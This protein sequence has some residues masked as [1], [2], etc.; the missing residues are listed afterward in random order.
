VDVG[1]NFPSF[2]D[3]LFMRVVAIFRRLI[4]H[5]TFPLLGTEISS[6]WLTSDGHI[7]RRFLLSS[8]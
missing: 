2:S 1:L 8:L 7:H 3:R 5:Y 6:K 4:Y